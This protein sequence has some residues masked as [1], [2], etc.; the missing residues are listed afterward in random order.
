MKQLKK[1]IENIKFEN[2]T[3][4]DKILEKFTVFFQSLFNFVYNFKIKKK[5]EKNK[6]IFFKSDWIESRKRA[7]TSITKEK[8]TIEW[9]NQFEK[10][11]NFL[12]IGAHMGIY[13]IYAAKLKNCNVLSVE[14]CIA[15]LSNL[16]YNSVI[17]D[18]ENKITICPFSIS[19]KSKIDKF[20]IF[21][22]KGKKKILDLAAG[23]PFLPVD[24]KGKNNENSYAHL[25]SIVT[26]DEL[27][28]KYGPFNYIKIDT[29]SNELEILEGSKTCIQDSKLKSILIELNEKS[30]TFKDIIKI[31]EINNFKLNKELTNKSIIAEKENSKRYNFIFEKNS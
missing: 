7:V 5:I 4:L 6:Y 9:I 14:P 16:N 28:E 12:D 8:N 3:L 10:D 18:L 21:K 1:K 2:F 31:F 13:S 19:N 30:E 11:S 23:L 22:H 24:D 20:Y 27:Y 15:N 17:N 25:T 29:D 26:V